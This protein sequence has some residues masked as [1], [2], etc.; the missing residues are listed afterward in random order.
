[1]PLNERKVLDI[2]IS[3]CKTM[4]ERCKGYQSELIDV[5]AEIITLERQHLVQAT[6]IQKKIN[7]KLNASGRLL[8]ERRLQ[9]KR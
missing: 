1:M 3:E 7:D 6:N 4:E 8:A 2:I 9:S 5:I